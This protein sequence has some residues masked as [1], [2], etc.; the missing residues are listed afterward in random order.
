[1]A[2]PLVWGP[3]STSLEVCVWAKLNCDGVHFVS[4]SVQDYR[5]LGKWKQMMLLL[6]VFFFFFMDNE[7]IVYK[8]EAHKVEA[9]EAEAA[10]TGSHWRPLRQWEYFTRMRTDSILLG[11]WKICRNK[12]N[13]TQCW[14]QGCYLSFRTLL[15]INSKVRE[16]SHFHWSESIQKLT[17][18]ASLGECHSLSSAQMILP[19]KSIF[20]CS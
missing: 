11:P 1:M 16:Q 18:L 6:L 20:L 2:L 7:V 12:L 8:T 19:F 9:L 13:Q 17:S 10:M 3:I 14:N 15:S 5:A 4:R